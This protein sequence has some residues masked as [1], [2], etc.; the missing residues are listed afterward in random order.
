ML[1]YFGSGLRDYAHKPVAA[2]RGRPA[3]EF[4]AVVGGAIAR[5]E[6]GEGEVPIFRTRSLWLSRPGS[7]H[8]WTGRHGTEA[9]VVV[10]HF[11]HVPKV[12]ELMLGDRRY[13]WIELTDD[14][15]ARLRELARGVARYRRKPSPGMLLAAEAALSD[16][17]LLVYEALAGDVG[18]GA[19]TGAREVG[20]ALQIYS[21]RMGENPSLATVAAEVGVSVAHLRRLFH[22][23]MGHGAKEAFAQLRERRIMELLTDTG[24][25]LEMIAEQTGFSESSALSRAFKARFGC[26]PSQVRLGWR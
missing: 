3:W 17:S 20:R 2:G 23:H 14:G 15:A 19:A 13:H 8:G 25:G 24:C 16:L 5:V 18:T 10:F 6:P 26:P 22:S 12:L 21:E 7:A 11:R 1:I 4:Q 9:E